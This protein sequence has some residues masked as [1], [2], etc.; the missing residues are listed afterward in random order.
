[1][2]F[3]DD[4]GIGLFVQG[5]PSFHFDALHYTV[6]DLA[7]AKHAHELK[8]RSEI[9]VHIDGWHMGVG[10]DTGWTDNVHPEYKIQPGIYEFSARM[11]P[12]AP[13][14]FPVHL[15]RTNIIP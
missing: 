3:T 9:V 1:M 11:R 15:G 5:A 4:N 6:D 8:P 7:I 12:L 10:G 13:G 2:A 14:D